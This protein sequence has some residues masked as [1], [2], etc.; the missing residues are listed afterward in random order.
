MD[1][2]DI[3]SEIKELYEKYILKDASDFC[4]NDYNTFNQAVCDLKDKYGMVNSVFLMLPEPAKE[5][6]FEMMNAT[7]DGLIEPS[8]EEKIKYIEKMKQSYKKL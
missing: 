4:L 1:N 3:I 6:D 8:F 5:A 2:L 7:N